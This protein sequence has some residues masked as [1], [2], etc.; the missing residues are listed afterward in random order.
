[1][2]SGDR[3][4][5]SFHGE[6]SLF[7]KPYTLQHHITMSLQSNNNIELTM[8]AIA[9]MVSPSGEATTAVRTPMRVRI[10]RLSGRKR[11]ATPLPRYECTPDR[12]IPNRSRMDVSQIK[13]SLRKESRAVATPAT[14]E[15]SKKRNYESCLRE[16][17][18]GTTNTSRMME[19]GPQPSKRSRMEPRRLSFEE[20]DHP[21]RQDILRATTIESFEQPQPV[22]SRRQSV[23]LVAPKVLDAPDLSCNYAVLSVAGSIAVS[24][25]DKV[26][27]WKDGKVELLVDEEGTEIT[28]V[29]WS[30]DGK[31]LAIGT[32]TGSLRVYKNIRVPDA[33]DHIEL[34]GQHRGAITAIAWNGK[35]QLAVA[36]QNGITRYDLKAE[37]PVVEA[38]YQGHGDDQVVALQWKEID[39]VSAGGDVVKLWNST[40]SGYNIPARKS[41]PHPGVRT[42]EFLPVQSNMIVSAGQEGLKYWNTWAGK[43]RGSIEI[44]SPVSSVICSSSKHEVLVAHG[45]KLSLWSAGPGRV[46][47][48]YER[49]ASSDGE[50]TCMGQG[51]GGTIVC[52]HSNEMLTLY[53]FRRDIQKEKAR[54]SLGVLNIPIL[55]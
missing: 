1:M 34:L 48:L 36:C 12:F 17:L 31:S 55:R 44:D 43:L 23:A 5:T 51:M 11:S 19:F 13:A 8:S 42:V 15:I 53:S 4:T 28:C 3:A 33:P 30:K 45:N 26:Y 52:A 22:S 37:Q 27:L 7:D 9:A 50:I 38:R 54:A 2:F 41:L 47:K 25:Y 20:N 40:A 16:V 35:H 10:P 18:F 46:E 21:L 32:M 49:Q 24:L 14:A 6:S 39:I 29:R